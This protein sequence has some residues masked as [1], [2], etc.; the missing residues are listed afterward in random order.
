[1]G[2]KRRT[3]M[4]AADRLRDEQNR[5]PVYGFRR[6]NE[7][8]S[9]ADR[10]ADHASDW[11]ADRERSPA[12]THPQRLYRTLCISTDFDPRRSAAHGLSRRSSRDPCPN[13]QPA[14]HTCAFRR[15]SR[16]LS[17]G[18]PLLPLR[19]HPRPAAIPRLDIDAFATLLTILGDGLQR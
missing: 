3:E 1:C 16:P 11:L 10:A 19:A 9:V 13:W 4:D 6:D 14:L 18:R 17:L 8:S 7:I 15:L 2:A 5:D 12:C